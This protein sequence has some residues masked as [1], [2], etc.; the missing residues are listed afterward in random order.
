MSGPHAHYNPSAPH[1]N[2]ATHHRAEKPGVKCGPK[3]CVVLNVY[4]KR[5]CSKGSWHVKDGRLYCGKK[6]RTPSPTPRSSSS[7][8][9]G[10]GIR[11]GSCASSAS[12]PD[13]TAVGVS[14]FD[15]VDEAAEAAIA[16]K[17]AWKGALPAAPA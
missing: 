5:S 14:V 10:A 16:E 1:H 13:A 8:S 4:K 9:F 12:T 3:G 15:C 6:F 17:G 11:D 2:V 7:A